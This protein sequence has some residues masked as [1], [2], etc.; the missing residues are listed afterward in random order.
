MAP[1]RQSR[2]GSAL[3]GRFLSADSADCRRFFE[4][5]RQEV[6][7]RVAP[8]SALSR[9]Y[10]GLPA[11]SGT[12]P[13]KRP[14]AYAYVNRAVGLQPAAAHH[15]A[16]EN[17]STRIRQ[18]SAR[19]GTSPRKRPPKHTHTSTVLWACSPQRHIT[20]HTKTQAYAY[21]N[22][23]PAAAHHPAY[24]N[25]STRIRQPCCG[26]AARS[27]TSPRKRPPSIR[28]RQPCCGLSARSGTSPRI[29]KPKHTHTSTV[30]W[31]FS[32]QRHITP[33]AG[34][35]RPVFRQSRS[36]FQPLL[37]APRRALS[38][39]SHKQTPLVATASGAGIWPGFPSTGFSVLWPAGSVS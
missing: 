13:R 12:S 4:D 39:P 36:G 11:R 21:V 3:T 32:P 5:W 19:S 14:Q 8:T 15:P 16:Y 2:S 28:I 20:P 31:A 23:Q 25:P 24:E 30:L 7:G 27:G 22:F 26:L 17:P 34:A 10:Y 35:K 37:A 33:P 9:S 1:S 18:L 38:S 29:R 6:Q